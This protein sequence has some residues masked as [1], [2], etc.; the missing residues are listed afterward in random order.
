[1]RENTISA[2]AGRSPTTPRIKSWRSF[3]G[4]RPP[5]PSAITVRDCRRI[6]R[7]FSRP[8]LI[9]SFTYGLTRLGQEFSGVPGTGLQFEPTALSQLEN[10][11]ARAKGRTNPLNNFVDDVTWTKGR[12]TITAGLN[13]RYNRN[14]VSAFTN[15]FP[16]YAYGATELIGLGEDIDNSVASLSRAFPSWRTQRP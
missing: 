4:N 11:S 5:L 6:I 9:N 8:T 16:L 10:W 2:C 15:S 14:Y 3:P 1:M 7:P 13:F 12:H